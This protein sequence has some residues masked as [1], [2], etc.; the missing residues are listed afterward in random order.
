MAVRC[1]LH[2]SHLLPLKKWLIED[3]WTIKDTDNSMNPFVVLRADKAGKRP[4]IIY[5][6][7]GAKEHYSVDPRDMGIIGA[8]MRDLKS[9]G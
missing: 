4:L 9:E 2:H 8:F 1:L 5:T 3:G 7:I 6:K